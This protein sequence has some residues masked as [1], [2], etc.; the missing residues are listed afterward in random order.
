LGLLSAGV[1]AFITRHSLQKEDLH[2]SDLMRILR[3]ALGR[4]EKNGSDG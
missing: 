4:R 2:A 1:S 3:R